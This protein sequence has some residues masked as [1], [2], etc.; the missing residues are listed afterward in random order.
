MKDETKVDEEI[1]QAVALDDA[2][3]R[4]EAAEWL[5]ILACASL[6]AAWAGVAWFLLIYLF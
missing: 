3:A 4:Q 2:A 1:R 5:N 6:L